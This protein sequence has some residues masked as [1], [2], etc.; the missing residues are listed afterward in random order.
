MKT[1][2]LILI[3]TSLFAIDGEKVFDKRC[4]SCHSKYIP[5]TKL[6]ENIDQDNELLHLK[7]PTINQLSYAL[8]QKAGDRTSS[9][10]DQKLEVEDFIGEYLK[11]PDKNR[12]ILSFEVNQFFKTMPKLEISDDELEAVSSYIFEYNDKMLEKLMP[13]IYP[14]KEAFKIAKK[15]NKIILLE[16]YLPYCRGCI[17]MDREVFVDKDIKNAIEKDFVF[18]KVNALQEKFP[19]GIKSRAT[20]TYFFIDSSGKK[21]LKKVRGTGTKKEFMDILKE[22]KRLHSS[23]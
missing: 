7:A 15:E 19:L 9:S 18:T 1:L 16:G 13:K 17:K 10:E 4:L 20:P 8:K 11:N 12:S 21:I 2:T 6:L 5:Q 14:Q 23:I 3:A 22:V